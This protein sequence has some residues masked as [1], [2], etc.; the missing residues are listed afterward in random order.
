MRGHVV[1]EQPA[2]G[3][4]D[5]LELAG[6]LHAPGVTLVLHRA[7]LVV[8]AAGPRAGR[9]PDIGRHP[10]KLRVVTEDVQ[11][12][13]GAR[14]GAE[15]VALKTHSM[16]EVSDRRLG[17]GQI[18][19]RLVVGTPHHLDSALGDEPAQVLAVLGMGVP[20][21]LEV[22]DLGEHEFV[23]RLAAGHLEMRTY[24]LQTVG[25]TAPAR[26]VLAPYAGVGRLR[27]PPDR[28]VVEVADHVHR[29]ARL[30][31]G[32]HE[33][34]LRVAGQHPRRPLLADDRTRNR[35]GH[36]DCPV[37]GIN[38]HRRRRGQTLA[39][40]ADLRRTA[41]VGDPHQLQRCVRRPGEQL[42][43]LRG[44]DVH[45]WHTTAFVDLSRCVRDRC[46]GRG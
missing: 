3:W 27:V 5:P 2:S 45:P 13:R 24:Q 11:L 17:A 31:D 33:R 41:S 44:D 36:F 20:V 35:H 42:R 9:Q 39:L 7:P 32:E 16:H 6:E 18:G 10:G 1:R 26:R 19:V 12:P 34:R 4:C 8:R 21:R 15:Y 37:G 25:L 43:R 40:D 14:V 28:V 29:P 38:D 23:L 30:G 22:V 46:G